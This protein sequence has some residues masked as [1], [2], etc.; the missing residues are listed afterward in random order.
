MDKYKNVKFAV[1]LSAAER[2][3]RGSP[4]AWCHSLQIEPACSPL[5]PTPRSSQYQHKMS[6]KLGAG[7]AVTR[8]YG[9]AYFRPHIIEQRFPNIVVTRG[10]SSHQNIVVTRGMSRSDQNI[11]VTRGMSRSHQ[12][13]VVTRGMS[14]SDQNIVV[15]RGMSRSHQNI[16]VTRGM[17]RSNEAP[18]E[19][20]RSIGQAGSLISY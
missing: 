13:I 2:V 20:H 14:R 19:P 15:T 8:Q 17:S 3:W 5:P 4:W 9:F 7:A 12:N 1:R 11:V 18:L 16:V 10:M 6:R